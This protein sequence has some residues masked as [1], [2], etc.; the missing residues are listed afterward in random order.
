[1]VRFGFSTNKDREKHVKMYHPDEA[2]A[3]GFVQL[4]RE[5]VEDARFSCQDCGKTFTRKANRDA[6]VR[7]HYGERPYECPSCE[8]A[9]TRV[10]DLRRHERN[11]HVR[12]RA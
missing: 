7:S 8:R 6:H 4:P 2:A 11:K 12:R 9:F 10:N 5:L 1:M 3:S